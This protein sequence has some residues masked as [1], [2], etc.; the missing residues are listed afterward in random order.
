MEFV[1]GFVNVRWTAAKSGYSTGVTVV[2]RAAPI[3]RHQAAQPEVFEATDL[4]TPSA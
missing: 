1:R 4:L 2:S 3:P